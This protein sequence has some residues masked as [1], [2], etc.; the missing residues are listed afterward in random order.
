MNQPYAV[1]NDG[2]AAMNGAKIQNGCL[3][4]SAD[5]FAI[6]VDAG[7]TEAEKADLLERRLSRLENELGLSSLGGR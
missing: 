4:I 5:R 3:L 7:M 1:T 6:K 2:N